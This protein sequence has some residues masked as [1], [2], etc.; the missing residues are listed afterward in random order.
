MV[1]MIPSV[2]ADG[3]AGGHEVESRKKK[4]GAT[5]IRLTGM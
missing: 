5:F 2:R 3:D 1:K 4:K